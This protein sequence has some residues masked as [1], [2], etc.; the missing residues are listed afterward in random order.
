M[1]GMTISV[2]DRV[3]RW[4]LDLDGDIYGDERERL[5]WYEGIATAAS[6]QWAAVPSAAAVLVWVLGRPAVV[7]LIVVLAVLVVPMMLCSAYVRGRRVDTVVRRWNRKR[8]ILSL[9]FTVPMVV[10]VFGAMWAYTGAEGSAWWG[11]VAGLALG[12]GISGFGPFVRP[13]RQR[14]EAPVVADED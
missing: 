5:R 12:G 11:A 7:P 8:T 6:L 10:F 2:L 13:G 14:R 1:E 9:A 3:V 4:S